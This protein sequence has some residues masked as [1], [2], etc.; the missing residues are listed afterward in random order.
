MPSIIASHAGDFTSDC[1]L[2]VDLLPASVAPEALLP[3]SITSAGV[4]WANANTTAEANCALM[5]SWLA[6]EEQLGG[7]L[8]RLRGVGA[9]RKR[10]L[11][12]VPDSGRLWPRTLCRFLELDVRLFASEKKGQIEDKFYQIG[13]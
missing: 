6:S 10:A 2:L 9:T 5:V 1:S 8:A 13:N 11:L 7:L 12:L 3:L 4:E